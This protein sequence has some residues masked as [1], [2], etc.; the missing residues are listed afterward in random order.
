VAPRRKEGSS[1]RVS[2]REV[3]CSDHVRGG[4]LRKVQDFCF[5]NQQP[6]PSVVL[7]AVNYN[8]DLLNCTSST[9]HLLPKEL[10]F[11][12]ERGENKASLIEGEGIVSFGYKHFRLGGSWKKI[13][14]L[15]IHNQIVDQHRTYTEWK[16][17]IFKIP[18]QAFLTGL[19][20]V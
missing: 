3:K 17:M 20:L 16:I 5:R 2:R 15:C 7:A 13:V 12:Y 8:P 11:V 18:R 1:T 9:L 14:T 19:M 4:I 6:A 10:D